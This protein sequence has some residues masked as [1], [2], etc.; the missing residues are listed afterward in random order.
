MEEIRDIVGLQPVNWWPLAW[1][2]WLIIIII[3]IIF[4]ATAF[5]MYRRYRFNKSW[6]GQAKKR[7]D[8]LSLNLSK[9]SVKETL[10]LLSLE[11]RN[12]AIHSSSRWECAGLTA[13]KWLEWLEKNDPYEYAWTKQAAILVD[14]PYSPPVEYPVEKIQG[15]IS[16]IQKWVRK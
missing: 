16:A 1:G 7:L 12:I 15:I 9:N 6:R 14:A 11:I 8:Q 5:F 10:S 4:I 3:S 13:N 2:V